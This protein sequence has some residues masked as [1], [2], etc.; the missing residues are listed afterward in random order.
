LDN[1]AYNYVIFNK[2]NPVTAMT[3]SRGCPHSACEFCNSKLYTLGKIRFRDFDAI[4]KEIEEVVFKYGIPEIFFRDQCFTANRE[5]V[6][7]ICEY[8]I[9]N[10]IDITWRAST[11]A[12]FVDK[13][14]L[15]LMRRAGCYQLSFGLETCSQE[16]LDVNNKG[17][18][19][20]QGRQ[21]IEWTK[22]ADIETTGLF[23]C[24]MLG[25]TE[26]NMKGLLRFAL[27]SGVDYAQFN[28]F[29]CD[30]G[31]PIYEKYKAGQVYL[32][33]ERI[34]K[35]YEKYSTLKFY[36]RPKNL[37]KQV[38]KIRSLKELKLLVSMLLDLFCYF[39]RINKLECSRKT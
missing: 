31:T 20:E 17:I 27:D 24:G 9:S 13:E 30:P 38:K 28:S 35:R 4:T 26:I 1:Q 11:R 2:R 6:W 36:L 12:D 10:N 14:L 37:L 15:F 19:I 32:L 39:L 3:I 34:A 25:D 18:T 33:P 21:A 29:G 5:L 8:I 16:V 23:M 22:G 7:K